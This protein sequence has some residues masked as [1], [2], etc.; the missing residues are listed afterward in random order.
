[1]RRLPLSAQPQRFAILDAGGN[2]DGDYLRLV[3][4][5]DQ[6]QIHL[7]PHHCCAKRHFHLMPQVSPG[8]R[9]PLAAPLRRWP[10]GPKRKSGSATT[11][12]KSPTS[13]AR[14]LPQQILQLRRQI[15]LAAASSAKIKAAKARRH[16]PRPLLPATAPHL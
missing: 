3:I 6:P 12:L 1:G 7:A 15:R 11:K 14:E 5:P 13:A 8:L 4:R 2:L 16:L 10:A 9:C